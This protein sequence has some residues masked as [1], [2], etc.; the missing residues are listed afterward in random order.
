[1]GGFTGALVIHSAASLLPWGISF[2]VGAMLF[3]SSNKIIPETHRKGYEQ[4]GT[5]G[6]MLLEFIVM[7]ILYQFL[8]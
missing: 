8:E 3:V 6:I 5:L 1:V 2:A 7:I 4:E